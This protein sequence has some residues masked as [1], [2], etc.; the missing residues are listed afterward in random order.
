MPSVKQSK[1]VYYG[2]LAKLL[3]Q[4][5]EE[6]NLTQNEV[7]TRLNKPQSFISKIESCE[8]RIDVIEL[9]E[10]LVLYRRPISELEAEIKKVLP[11]DNRKV[12]KK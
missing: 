7:A 6:A 4:Y 1:R 9:I 2:H 3:R 11:F 8:R 10:L 12:Q 5:R